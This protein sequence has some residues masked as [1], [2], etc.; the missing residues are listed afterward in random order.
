MENQGLRG[1]FTRGKGV[2]GS[3]S[4]SE[5]GSVRAL[6]RHRGRRLALVIAGLCLGAAYVIYLGFAVFAPLRG[7]S[8]GDTNMPAPMPTPAAAMQEMD[9]SRA[10]EGAIAGPAAGAGGTVGLDAQANQASQPWDRMVIRTATL[11]LTVEDV[12]AGVNQVTALA[13][14]YGGRVMQ[15]DTHVQ[16]E[17][18]VSTVTIQVPGD[19][20][21]QVLP[22]LRSLGGRVKKVL[23]ENV[24]GQDVTE[25]YT[26]LQSQLRNLKATETRLL[27]L[28]E[29]ATTVPDVLALDRELRQIQAEVERIQGRTNYLSKRSEMSTI[30][31]TLS[32]PALL[33]PTLTPEP[34]KVWDPAEIAAR[35]WNASLDL[36]T[37]IGTVVI[38][39]GVFLWWLLPV[40]L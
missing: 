26:D 2:E 17:Y 37:N 10:Q 6:V 34:K 38:T 18:S 3:R 22:E 21:E 20:F 4:A 16:G 11:N 25:E 9:P 5:G 14:R 32:P 15:M 27:Q 8:L 36:L 33:E 35:A 24:S 1:Y 29:K 28:Y 7:A 13:A 19:E 40:L 23:A 12:T 31:I 39:V 30:T